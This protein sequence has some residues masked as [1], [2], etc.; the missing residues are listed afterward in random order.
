MAVDI[1]KSLNDAELKIGIQKVLDFE[2]TEMTK[3]ISE[4]DYASPI[5][6]PLLY[7]EKR[8]D[9]EYIDG[10][11]KQLGILY[12]K[13]I[14]DPKNILAS[15]RLYNEVMRFRQKQKINQIYKPL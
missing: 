7:G 13:Q 9:R 3:I 6:F 5:A 4:L 15:K 10:Q 12:K 1:H 8:I 2:N 11:A 14:M